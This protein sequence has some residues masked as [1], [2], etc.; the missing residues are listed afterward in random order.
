MKPPPSSGSTPSV[1]PSMAVGQLL[2]R[3]VGVHLEEPT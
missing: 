3:L 2:Q 1:L